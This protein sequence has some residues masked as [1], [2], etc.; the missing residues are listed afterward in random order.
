VLDSEF[1]ESI[2]DAM[3]RFNVLELFYERNELINMITKDKITNFIID[4]LLS[5]A[6]LSQIQLEGFASDRL[7]PN[8][9]IGTFKNVPLHHI[10]KKK[11]QSSNI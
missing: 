9:E 8:K 4:S 2:V 6:H 1:E 5:S 3:K 10:L 7:I 11:K